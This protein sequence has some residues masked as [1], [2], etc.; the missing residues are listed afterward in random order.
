MTSSQWSSSCI[1]REKPLSYFQ[2]SVTTRAAEFITLCNLSVMT[3]QPAQH[4]SSRHEM[5]QMLAPGFLADPTSNDCRTRQICLRWKKH[6]V[7]TAETCFSVRSTK[8][9]GVR[10]LTVLLELG[11]DNEGKRQAVQHHLYDWREFCVSRIQ[12]G[13]IGHVSSK[14]EYDVDGTFLYFLN[15]FSLPSSPSY[16]FPFSFYI[17]FF[18]SYFFFLSFPS[19]SL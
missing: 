15:V 11:G 16:F 1:D 7:L 13:G 19:F 12:H 8:Y 10:L 17:L 9:E 3:T 2:V 5:S 4:Y 18:F 14:V 6:V